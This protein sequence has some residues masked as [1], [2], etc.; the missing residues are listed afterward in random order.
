MSAFAPG[1]SARSAADLSGHSGFEP[2]AMAW[3]RKLKA[4]EIDR[5]KKQNARRCMRAFHGKA[6]L[7]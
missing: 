5:A 3:R 2:R 7:C 4:V 1:I 6:V